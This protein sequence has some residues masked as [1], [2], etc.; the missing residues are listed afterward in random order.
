M[1]EPSCLA[2]MPPLKSRP[3]ATE[4][5][6]GGIMSATCEPRYRKRV[7]CQLVVGDGSGMGHSDNHT[8]MRVPVSLAGGKQKIKT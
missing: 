8:A 3:G 2:K 4:S 1:H 6:T 5:S 7:P